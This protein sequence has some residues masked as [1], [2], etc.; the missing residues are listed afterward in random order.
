[1][2]EQT[3]EQTCGQ[4]LVH[5][6]CVSDRGVCVCDLYEHRAQPEDHGRR[7]F[8]HTNSCYQRLWRSHG[9][10]H[11]SCEKSHSSLELFH[12]NIKK[13]TMIIMGE[14]KSE[15][16]K[17]GLPICLTSVMTINNFQF[18]G[19]TIIISHFIS[20][21]KWL[22]ITCASIHIMQMDG[23]PIFN[24]WLSHVG[25]DKGMRQS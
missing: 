23:L 7:S 25:S 16:L 11:L 4:I 22:D 6:S 5:L 12:S 8:L 3:S 17:G 2:A 13:P 24:A 20:F 18:G 9:H 1:M 15:V 14:S 10:L 21:L 19:L